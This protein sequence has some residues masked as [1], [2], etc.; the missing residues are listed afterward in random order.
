MLAGIVLKSVRSLTLTSSRRLTSKHASSLKP[1]LEMQYGVTR[2]QTH[3]GLLS[4]EV[5]CAATEG[6][7]PK[8]PLGTHLNPASYIYRLA[9]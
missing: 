4:A 9:S 8:I 6:I 5:P 7:V 1:S 3:K 2:E